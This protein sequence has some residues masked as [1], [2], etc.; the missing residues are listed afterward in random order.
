[1]NVPRALA[2]FVPTGVW[3]LQAITSARVLNMATPCPQMDAL[4][5]VSDLIPPPNTKLEYIYCVAANSALVCLTEFFSEINLE[6]AQHPFTFNRVWCESSAQI[7]I[8]GSLTVV[9]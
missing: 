8:I 4:A 7:K 1:M 3:I 9:Q 2:T 6:N 5:E